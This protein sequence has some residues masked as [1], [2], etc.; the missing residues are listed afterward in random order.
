V[1][2]VFV[3]GADPQAWRLLD[4]GRL[5]D[6][7]AH[8][9]AF[10]LEPSFLE[11]ATRVTDLPTRDAIGARWARFLEHQDLCGYDRAR[12]G[13]LGDELIRSAVDE[14]G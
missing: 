10:R 5:Q 2:R 12:L 8:T 14:A 3:D 11:D 4:H 6:A 1:V 9:L 7:F 13:T